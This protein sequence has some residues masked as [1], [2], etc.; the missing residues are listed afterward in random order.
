MEM[1][2]QQGQ[3]NPSANAN[4]AITKVLSQPVDTAPSYIRDAISG[5]EQYLSELHE[6]I[7]ALEKRMDTILSPAPPTVQATGNGPRTS[8]VGGGSHVQGR[9]MIINEGF[10]QESARLRDI[11]RRVEV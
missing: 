6:T 9:L 10:A 4:A 11:I 5:S 8:P 1:S 3:W 2:G 7:N